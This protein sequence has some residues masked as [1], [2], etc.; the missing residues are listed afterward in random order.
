MLIVQ[1]GDSRSADGS[2]ALRKTVA[3]IRGDGLVRGG[4]HDGIT[5]LNRLVKHVDVM[6]VVVFSR[7]GFVFIHLT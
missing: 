5:V 7:S 2:R 6:L 1:K 3:E 4:V